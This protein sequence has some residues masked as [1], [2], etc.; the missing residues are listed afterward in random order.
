LDLKKAL[1]LTCSFFGTP[2]YKRTKA[3][4]YGTWNRKKQYARRDEL[5]SS[6]EETKYINELNKIL[7]E[8]EEYEDLNND[9][10]RDYK[11][12]K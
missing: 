9:D 8:Q 10:D 11:E 2:E 5:N 4:M 6:F 1:I 3:K 7:N 12:E